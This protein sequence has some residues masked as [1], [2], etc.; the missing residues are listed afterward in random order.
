M[1]IVWYFDSVTKV[2]ETNIS[3]CNGVCHVF[4]KKGGVSIQ[5]VQF[6]VRNTLFIGGNEIGTKS[7]TIVLSWFVVV[8][9]CNSTYWLGIE[10]LSCSTKKP[11]NHHLSKLLINMD[12]FW[13]HAYILAITK[14]VQIWIVKYLDQT[15]S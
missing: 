4:W 5:H 15:W 9:C 3:K 6:I 1:V 8:T 12:N 10:Y 14:V 7:I 2:I 13:T 11:F